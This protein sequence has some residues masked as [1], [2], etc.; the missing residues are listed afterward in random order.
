MVAYFRA[1]NAAYDRL[2]VGRALREALFVGFLAF[3]FRDPVNGP[4]ELM[5]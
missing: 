5:R 1:P 2:G 3:F 4:K